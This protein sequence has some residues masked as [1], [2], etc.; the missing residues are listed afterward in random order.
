MVDANM[1]RGRALNL[2]GLFEWESMAGSGAAL[3][4]RMRAL[5]DRLRATTPRER[6]LLGLL[7]LGALIYAPIMASDFR[8]AQEDRYV[9]ALGDR[10]STTLMQQAARRI[11]AA[12][13]NRTALEDMRSWG[14]EAANIPIAQVA[15]EQRL[16][17]AA[18][19]AQMINPRIT[20][21]DQI[22]TIG[23]TQWL[24]AE[25]Q[26]DLRWTPTF[27][28]LD[29]VAAWPEGFRV[30]RFQY[31]MTPPPAFSEIEP[32]APSGRVVIGLAFPV[33]IAATNGEGGA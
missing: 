2:S 8:A 32:V 4:E 19:N 33:S 3:R 18:T 1:F 11:A 15:I 24:E 7:G 13:E 9:Q 16:V 20:V 12:T 26:A 23:A 14:F 22:E 29:D 17:K 5:G 27:A 30:T 25:I 28:F 31:E 21:R 6:L 10:A